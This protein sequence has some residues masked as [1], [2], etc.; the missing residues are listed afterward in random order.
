MSDDTCPRCPD[1]DARDTMKVITTVPFM[2]VRDSGWEYLSNGRGMYVS[3]LATS[4]DD[5]NAYCR[6][7]Q[8]AKEK[9]RKRGLRV[10]DA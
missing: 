2:R 6:S 8:E 4:L 9:A 7:R 5:P 3:Q 1:C 10:E